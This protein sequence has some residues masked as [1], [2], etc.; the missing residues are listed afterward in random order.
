MNLV[1]TE[2]QGLNDMIRYH[3]GWHDPLAQRGKRLRPIIHL[4]ATMAFGKTFEDGI[5]SAI[6]LEVFHNFTLVHDDIQDKG[7]FRQGR[8]ALWT[9]EY[10]FE[11]AIN[12]GDFW[13]M[14]LSLY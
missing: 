3:F 6:A 2:N 7:Q 4:L 9:T 11:Q 10:G 12:T 1:G 8:P 13:P 5:N 14:L